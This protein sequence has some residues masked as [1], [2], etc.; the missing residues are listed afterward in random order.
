MQ[1]HAHHILFFSIAGLIYKYPLLCQSYVNERYL[2]L[3]DFF[4]IAY[5]DVN[6]K[7]SFVNDIPIEIIKVFSWFIAIG[8][9][10]ILLHIRK[11]IIFY[12][13]IIIGASPPNWK[14]NFKV[15]A[16]RIGRSILKSQH[17]EL[18]GEF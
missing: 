12:A 16:L 11:G 5:P 3:S 7:L 18:E 14:E 9:V 17:S 2:Q 1:T 8:G 10:I 4:T 13:Y 15:P 6:F